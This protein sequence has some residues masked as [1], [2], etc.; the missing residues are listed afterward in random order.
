MMKYFEEREEHGETDIGGDFQDGGGGVETDRGCEK[1]RHLEEE[2]KWKGDQEGIYRVA[3]KE[4]NSRP[5]RT[6]LWPTV[7]FLHL[8]G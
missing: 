2:K 6:L 7:I 3:Q 1:L 4:R 5:F 8:A